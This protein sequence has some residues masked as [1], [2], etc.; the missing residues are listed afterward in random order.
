MA[1]WPQFGAAFALLISATSAH[2]AVTPEDIWQ[3]WQA[4]STAMGQTM[5]AKST[6]RDG[7]TLVVSGITISSAQ[8]GATVS[9]ALDEVRLL[10]MG[11]GTVSIAMSP[12]YPINMTLPPN[13]AREKPVEI[14]ITI[15]Q[16]ELVLTASGDPAAIHYAALAP[17][18]KVKL[19]RIDGVD[20]AAANL[21]VEAS[22]S[23]ISGSYGTSG[24]GDAMTVS[25]DFKASGLALAVIG[26]DP[27][28][29]SEVRITSALK[30]INLMSSG[31]MM[32]AFAGANFVEALKRGANSASKMTVGSSDFDI[33]IDGE[34]GPITVKGTAGAGDL[35]ATVGPDGLSYTARQ[36]G[37]KMAMSMSAMPAGDMSVGF[38][39]SSFAVKMPIVPS[40]EPAPFSLQTRLTNMTLSDAVWAMFDPKSALPRDPLNLVIDTD[41]M[42]KVKNIVPLD[43]TMPTSIPAEVQ[44]LNLKELKLSFAGTELTG[45]GKGSFDYAAGPMPN[46]A[47]KLDFKLLGANGLMDKL[48]AAGFIQAADLMMPRMMMAMIAQP[49]AGA[50]ELLSTI[51]IKDKG[52]FANGQKLYDLP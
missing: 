19:T 50:D 24:A 45:A 8:N 41:G 39:E 7:D 29:G 46:A 6:Q 20:A 47:A 1:A 40:D 38:D 23:D 15:S 34:S 16:Q 17:N 2:A 14:A 44:S 52:V 42:A 12:D 5:T 28:A 9:A 31:A 30:D 33:A 37:V 35:A 13:Q 10:D 3:N 18:V 4:S 49:G 27:K 25:S 43:G 36:T 26:A 11:D 21:A 22:L 32:T 51:E 48:V